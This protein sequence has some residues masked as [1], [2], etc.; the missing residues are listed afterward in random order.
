MATFIDRI[1]ELFDAAKDRNYRLTQKE[2]AARFG[3]TRNQ[4]KG[5]LDGRGEPDSELMKK[6]AKAHGVSV[7]W[8]VGESDTKNL[9][10]TNVYRRIEDSL[11]DLPDE[12]IRSIEEYIELIRIKY[13]RRKNARK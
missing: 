7:S 13:S 8:L 2:Y 12:A 11:S 4:L 6:V 5:W 1:N 10:E 9:V 3:A